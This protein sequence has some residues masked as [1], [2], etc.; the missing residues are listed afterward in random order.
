MRELEEKQLTISFYF[1]NI[2]AYIIQYNYSMTEVSKVHLHK[3]FNF[4]FFHQ[5]HPPG[6]LIPTLD[7]LQI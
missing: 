4:Y 7:Y 6:L 5:K 2:V 1:V 3:I